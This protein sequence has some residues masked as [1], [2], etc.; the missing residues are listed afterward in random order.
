MISK[1][2]LLLIGLLFSQSLAAESTIDFRSYPLT[3]Q[4]QWAICYISKD[5]SNPIPMCKDQQYASQFYNVVVREMVE[6]LDMPEVQ[7]CYYNTE[8]SNTVV[9]VGKT[10]Y[11]NITSNNVVFGVTKNTAIPIAIIQTCLSIKK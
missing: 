11:N 6:L 9:L 2:K 7:D 10:L 8:L 3:S 5:V 1:T 4:V